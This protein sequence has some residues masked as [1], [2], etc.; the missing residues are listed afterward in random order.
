MNKIK[1]LN[2]IA[3]LV[4]LLLLVTAMPFQTVLAA[5]A[6]VSVGAEPEV[7][8]GSQFYA[9]IDISGVTNLASWELQATYKADLISIIG[10]ESII[11][12]NAGKIGSIASR[13]N[14]WSYSPAGT[15]GTVLLKGATASTASGNGTLAQ[16]VFKANGSVG[17]KCD[18]TLANIKLTDSSGNSIS[19]NGLNG[20]VTIVAAKT[21]TPPPATTTT[22]AKTT[23]PPPASTTPAKTTT[24]PATSP[25][26]TSPA[27]AQPPRTTTP[28]PSPSSTAVK[29]TPS[30][31]VSPASTSSAASNTKIAIAVP[32]KVQSLAEF[33]VRID[34]VKVTGLD[35]FHFVLEYDPE[36]LEV[37]DVTTGMIG[38]NE[39]SITEWALTPPE[40]QGKVEIMGAIKG[41]KGANGSG[42]LAKI[43]CQMISEL[44]KTSDL[45]LS[46]VE[47]TDIDGNTLEIGPVPQESIEVEATKVST[48]M[49]EKVPQNGQ[50]DALVEITQVT[51][52]ASYKVEITYNPSVIDIIEVNPGMIASTEVPVDDW[53]FVPPDEQGQISIKGAFDKDKEGA[54]GSGYLAKIHC[55]AIGRLSQRGS[56]TIKSV[57]LL[58]ADGKPIAQS[59]PESHSILIANPSFLSSTT[60]LVIVIVAAL[61]VIGLILFFFLRRLRHRGVQKAARPA[62]PPTG[63]GS[64]TPKAEEPEDL[65]EVMRSRISQLP[66]RKGGR[67][68]GSGDDQPK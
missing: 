64:K 24:P 25:G 30:T 5:S 22:P 1:I 63:K 53:N 28:S 4:I 36:V 9:T 66:S 41:G 21:T 68:P 55:K 54:R 46:E 13:V 19:A 18:I 23:T 3:G 20:S 62:A 44:G 16:F 11:G 42:F 50:F 33:V 35:S 32:P 2:I 7:V 65:M 56:L 61:A 45:T 26:A 8:Q 12:V 48:T 51:G 40:T 37:R 60:G 10:K 52:L 31:S 14:S 49:P 29:P 39:V 43:H 6:T 15:P 57:E 58:D 67:K 34:I 59:Q 38:S 17:S 27:A 47:M